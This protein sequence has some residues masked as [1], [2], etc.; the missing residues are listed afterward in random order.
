[1]FGQPKPITAD[2]LVEAHVTTLL[3]V[4][5]MPNEIKDALA[6]QITELHNTYW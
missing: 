5:F 6:R 3:N 2:Q 4:G 1:V